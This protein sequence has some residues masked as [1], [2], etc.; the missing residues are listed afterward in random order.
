VS[1]RGFAVPL[2]GAVAFAIFLIGADGAEPA[3]SPPAPANVTGTP[4]PSPYDAVLRDRVPLLLKLKLL[5]A[6]SETFE[7]RSEP[8][9]REGLDK[10]YR[11]T[12]ARVVA[13][14]DGY[15]GKHPG[16]VQA[17]YDLG[18]L[19]Y[20]VGSDEGRAAELWNRV[21]ALDPSHD[22]AHNALAVHYGDVA[23][24]E[25]AL[26]HIGKALELNPDVAEYHFNAATHYFNFRSVAVRVFG[27]DL[28]AV[29]ER[30]MAEYRKAVELDPQNY[31][32]AK[33]Y[34]L[35]FYS[36]VYFRVPED[37]AAAT[38]AWAAVLSLA[39]DRDRRAVVLEH[40]TRVSMYTGNTADAR[41]YLEEALRIHPQNA[42]L[43]LLE[44]RLESGERLPTPGETFRTPAG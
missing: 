16:D 43:R 12:F 11:D 25:R 34:A 26:Q 24:P 32:F 9:K 37:Y 23:E 10:E 21:L 5:E 2:V 44:R 29:W 15:L 27:W 42:T 28:P 40:L 30:S 41:R 8:E 6:R 14:Y 20:D 39:P 4:K 38:R 1:A 36:A 18:M 3:P 22:R 19:C 17:L 33:A 7:V 35:S 13:L 31:E